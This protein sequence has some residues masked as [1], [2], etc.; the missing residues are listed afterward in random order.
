MLLCV[1]WIFFCNKTVKLFLFYHTE[2]FY[3]MVD[4]GMICFLLECFW[5]WCG[6]LPTIL[7][8]DCMFSCKSVKLKHKSLCSFW[9]GASILK[10]I[11]CMYL[12]KWKQE[13]FFE[14]NLILSQIS[15]VLV[16]LVCAE[17]DVFILK[18]RVSI[19]LTKCVFEKKMDIW[20]WCRCRST[21]ISA[22]FLHP[23]SYQH[24]HTCAPT[25]HP[26]CVWFG[27][28]SSQ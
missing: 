18:W 22:F 11:D 21:H 13:L 27:K 19:Y 23:Y 2:Y 25:H 5:M 3:C 28:E 14:N 12:V 26:V 24:T 4:K 9:N 6:H 15:S 10:E 1:S 20:I 16:K 8:V 7:W 17:K